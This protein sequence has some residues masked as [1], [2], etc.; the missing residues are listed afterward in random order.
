[1]SRHRKP[2]YGSKIASVDPVII[3]ESRRLDEA[4]DCP[5][6][7]VP[8]GVVVNPPHLDE[9]ASY[10]GEGD[11]Y[12]TTSKVKEMRILQRAL[13]EGWP[14]TAAQRQWIIGVLVNVI[15]S[16]SSE[17]VM[18]QAINA[19]LKADALNLALLKHEEPTPQVNVNLNIN[20]ESRDAEIGDLLGK[21]ESRRIG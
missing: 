6:E 13:K 17:K 16:P 20:A 1:M 10:L 15:K 2:R 5:G 19:M 12:P 9:S 8:C 4:R 21:P 11:E 18:L 7:V 14:I 3:A